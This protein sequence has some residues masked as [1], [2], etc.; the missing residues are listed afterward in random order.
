MWYVLTIQSILFSI[1][2]FTKNNNFILVLLPPIWCQNL[3]I[4]SLLFFKGKMIV[5]ICINI[6]DT[7]LF[8]RDTGEWH[9]MPQKPGLYTPTP[10]DGHGFNLSFLSQ[11]TSNFSATSFLLK[12]E[13]RSVD[14]I[15]FESLPI[16][17]H[18]SKI[19]G[20]FLPPASKPEKKKRIKFPCVLCTYF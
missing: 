20:V 13:D 2:Y 9:T 6:L 3:Q 12:G 5:L 8:C 14:K 16:W 11:R 10:C 1:W 17:T 19:D 18:G 15:I 7:V 4:R